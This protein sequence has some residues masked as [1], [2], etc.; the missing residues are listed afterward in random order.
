MRLRTRGAYKVDK[1]VVSLNKS[2]STALMLV[3]Y[4][5]LC[6]EYRCVEVWR[7]R[8]WHEVMCAQSCKLAQRGKDTSV[9]LT[10]GVVVQLTAQDVSV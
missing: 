2:T 6:E 3:L 7:A 5:S 4:R 9:K 8:A 10:D 1:L